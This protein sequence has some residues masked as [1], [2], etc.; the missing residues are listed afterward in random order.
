VPEHAIAG[1]L[2]GKVCVIAGAAGVIGEAT[3][4]RVRR[5]GAVVIGVDQREHSVG[6]LCL[7][8]DLT[9]PHGALPPPTVIR[10]FR[11]LGTHLAR[12]GVRVNALCLGP[13]ETPQLRELFSRLPP[14]ELPQAAHPHP[15]GRLGTVEE[16]ARRM[17]AA[18]RIGRNAGWL[19]HPR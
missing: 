19:R 8:A 4:E 16:L 3:A 1:R 14:E 15:M 12:R 11:D 17:P 5:E 9:V 18:P 7:E 2:A 10:L 13:I 6:V